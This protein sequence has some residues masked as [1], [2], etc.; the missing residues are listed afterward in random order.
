[1]SAADNSAAMR[2]A[3]EEAYPTPP[4]IG[5]TSVATALAAR[6]CAFID[7][8]QWAW[9]EAT[10]RA[11]AKEAALR[12][13]VERLVKA[14]GRFHTEQN[15]RALVDALAAAAPEEKEAK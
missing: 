12:T 5:H 10:R 7:G 13:A 3:A 1:V 6:R 2:A 9:Q 8:A 4:G 11:S 14:K 15:Y